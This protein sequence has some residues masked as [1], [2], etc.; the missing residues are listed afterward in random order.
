MC[1]LKVSSFRLLK[2]SGRLIYVCLLTLCAPVHASACLTHLHAQ[3]HTVLEC[4]HSCTRAFNI[5]CWARLCSVGTCKDVYMYIQVLVFNTSRAKAHVSLCYLLI[6]S[7]FK[8][9]LSFDINFN[10][11]RN[12]KHT[13]GSPYI[14]FFDLRS[15]VKVTSEVIIIPKNLI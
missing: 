8:W 14:L 3:V 15:K 9:F 5:F 4:M 11:G 2:W 12:V 10:F 13:S 7:D 6:V 1:G